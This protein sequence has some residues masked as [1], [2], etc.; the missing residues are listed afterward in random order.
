V[1]GAGAGHGVKRIGH[2]HDTGGERNGVAYQSIRVPAAVE[3]LVVRS[4]DRENGRTSL[5]PGGQDALAD[6]RVLHQTVVLVSGE[7]SGLGQN[8]VRYTDLPH[9]VK[10]GRKRDLRLL[11]WTEPELSSD[12]AGVE[13]YPIGMTP[14]ILVFGV[15]R[16]DERQHR[17]RVL[18][19]G[20]VGLVRFDPGKTVGRHD[21]E[22]PLDRGHMP[23]M[24]CNSRNCAH[25]L[26]APLVVRTPSG[27]SWSLTARAM[28]GPGRGS[29][30]TWCF[31]CH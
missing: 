27:L 19:G 4:H 18:G 30:T 3:T 14:R 1:I 6:H 9:I 12:G 11:V 21:A 15:E 2:R 20:P 17:R 23:L 13:R 8:L 26:T 16:R 7:A 5:E 31:A 28:R 29:G 10:Y 24:S 22:P 25:S